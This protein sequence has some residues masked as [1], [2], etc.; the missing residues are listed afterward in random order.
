MKVINKKRV[1]I[2]KEEY[3]IES[4]ADNDPRNSTKIIKYKTGS[5]PFTIYDSQ[6]KELNQLNEEELIQEWIVA[7]PKEREILLAPY[8][9]YFRHDLYRKYR[10]LFE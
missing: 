9:Y 6:L 1:M 10:L 3:V 4:F 2:D 8:L 5:M 7:T